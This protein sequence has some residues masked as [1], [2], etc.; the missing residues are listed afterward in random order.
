MFSD[1]DVTTL[2]H[3]HPVVVKEE[4]VPKKVAVVEHNPEKVVISEKA[5]IEEVKIDER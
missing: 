2:Q 4:I 3:E 5:V 1:P